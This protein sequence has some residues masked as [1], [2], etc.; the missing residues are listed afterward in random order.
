MHV[1]AARAGGGDVAE[2]SASRGA[3][4]S[5]PIAIR[6]SVL[7]PTCITV[8]TAMSGQPSM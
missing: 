7:W 6:R 5:M 2:S 1:D 3:P 4:F 8:F